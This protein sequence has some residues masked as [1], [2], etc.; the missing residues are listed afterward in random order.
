VVLGRQGLP[1]PL[2]EVI[3]I[4]IFDFLSSQKK[5]FERKTLEETKKD[6]KDLHEHNI[7][8]EHLEKSSLFGSSSMHVDNDSFIQSRLLISEIKNKQELTTK[9]G[10]LAKNISLLRATSS[11]GRKGNMQ[12]TEKILKDEYC[13]LNNV[14]SDLSVLKN[15]LEKIEKLHLDLMNSHVSLD[16]KTVMEQEFSR[17]H[18]K[19][20]EAYN[21][22]KTILLNLSSIFINLAR[23][24]TTKK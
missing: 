3:K 4:N 7:E 18:K 16:V 19:L 24:S 23:D 6:I 8:F 15:S 1:A 17:K 20:N 9:L 22:Q 11:K 14:I 13:G 12:I 2:P 21:K 10:H 5:G